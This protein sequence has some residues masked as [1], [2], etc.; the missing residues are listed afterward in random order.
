MEWFLPGVRKRP[1]SILRCPEGTQSAC[2]FQKHPMQGMKHVEQVMLKE[3]SGGKGAYLCPT[4]ATSIIELVQ[5]GVIEFHPW[6]GLAASPDKADRIV[7]DLDPA[8]DVS[9][10]RVVAAART[11]RRLLERLELASFVRTTGGKGLHVVVPLRPS[12]DWPAVEQFAKAFAMSL[13]ESQPDEFIAVSTK[14]RRKGRIFIDYLRNGRGATSVASYS[15][16]AREGA[17]VAV[18]LR[19][20][21]L[22]KIESGAAFDIRTTVARLKRLRRDPWEEMAAMRQSLARAMRAVSG[23]S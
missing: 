20:E 15:L 14:A 17:P 13:A 19:W 3:S 4:D 11:T 8:E 16:R 6:G 21:E 2:F 10:E 7:F 1:L 12:A 23:K 22:A 9:W 5:F 18:P